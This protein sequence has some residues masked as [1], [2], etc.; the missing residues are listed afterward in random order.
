MVPW[1]EIVTES[2]QACRASLVQNFLNHPTTPHDST[3]WSAP[4]L[5]PHLKGESFIEGGTDDAQEQVFRGADHR[6]PGRAGEGVVDGRGLPS[7][8]VSSATFYKWKARYGGLD[9]SDVRRLKTLETENARQKR[10]LA[11][12]ELDKAV[13]KDLLGNG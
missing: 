9:V 5:V 11:E 12:A 3:V 13:L 10:L 4:R 1:L 6:D 2:H 8:W 7:A